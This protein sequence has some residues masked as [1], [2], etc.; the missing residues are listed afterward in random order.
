MWGAP[1]VH[2]TDRGRPPL[3]GGPA[4]PPVTVAQ[5]LLALH[6]LDLSFSGLDVSLVF[7]TGLLSF[8][9]A[10]LFPSASGVPA[11]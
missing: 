10:L 5:P 4:G 1:D 9:L 8:R 3:H 7:F 11:S 2:S 6:F